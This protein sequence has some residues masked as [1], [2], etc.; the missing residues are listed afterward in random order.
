MTPRDTAIQAV[1][2]GLAEVLKTRFAI[3]SGADDE[4]VAK[5]HFKSGLLLLAK[6][7]KEA[8]A[9]VEAVFSSDDNGGQA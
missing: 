5:R 8:I 1:N 3:F 2:D 4:A 7:H 9:L 6:A